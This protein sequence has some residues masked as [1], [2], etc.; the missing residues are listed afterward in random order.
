MMHRI[1]SVAAP[2][3]HLVGPGQLK[4]INGQLAFKRH[5]DGPLRLDP[6]A[7]TDIYCYG[8]ISVSGAAMELLFRHGIQTAWLSQGGQ[9]C[10][11]R[12]SRTDAPT[13]LT[14]IRQHRV[15]G[16]ATHRR[17]WAK[18]VVAGKIE[19]MTAAARRYQRNGTPVGSL[20]TDLPALSAKLAGAETAEQVRGLEG[21]AS[22]SWFGFFSLLFSAPWSF[23]TRNRRPPTD[24]VNALL[25]LGYT[26]LLNR[27]TSRAE[28]LGYEIYI[29]GLHEYRAGRPSLSCDLM[30]ALRVPA[31]D[32]WVVATCGQ[33]ELSPSD[34][35][36]EESGGLRLQPAA[37]GRTLY[38]W[39]KHWTEQRLDTA[40]QQ[41]LETLARF[42]RDRT[43]PEPD[44]ERSADD[45]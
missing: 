42:I 17:D 14:R 9:R 7:L 26:W 39:E 45:L 1:T 32:R 18:L 43:G 2:V 19:A 31:V 21:A 41:W 16:D 27:T 3:A 44:E 20:L 11:G 13:T 38:L 6:T 33:G 4:V 24:P 25:S 10:R 35:V 5:G 22:A 15:F 23:S 36:S 40:L 28:A 37:F 30:E 29:G 12:L 34:F 8:D